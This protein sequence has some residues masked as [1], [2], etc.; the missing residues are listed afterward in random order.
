MLGDI[1]KT[2]LD[3]IFENYSSFPTQAARL[4]NTMFLIFLMDFLCFKWFLRF[5]SGFLSFG[6]WFS[7][8]LS[9]FLSCFN[10]F[11]KLFNCF[12]VFFQLLDFSTV[13]YFVHFVFLCVLCR[14]SFF[15]LLCVCGGKGGVVQRFSHVFKYFTLVFRWFSSVFRLFSLVSNGFLYVLGSW[16]ILKMCLGDITVNE[17]LPFAASRFFRLLGDT[18]FLDV[19]GGVL[20]FPLFCFI[21]FSTVFSGLSPFFFRFGF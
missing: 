12:P 3:C 5:C 20:W 16:A 14:F 9:V 7:S 18:G 2:N 21:G 6:Q 1:G 15:F 8:V 10:S 13:F 17:K 19:R 4:G 11:L